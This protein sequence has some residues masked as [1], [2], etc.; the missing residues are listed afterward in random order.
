VG[1]NLFLI[2]FDNIRDKTRVLEGIPWVFEGNLFLVEDFDGL[3][4][5]S[6]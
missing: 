3:S 1:E 2:E 6:S 5:P 4:L